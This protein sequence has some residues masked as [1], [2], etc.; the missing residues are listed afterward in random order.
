LNFAIEDAPR[1]RVDQGVLTTLPTM[2]KINRLLAIAGSWSRASRYI[3]DGGLIRAAPDATIANYALADLGRREASGEGPLQQALRIVADV[4][5]KDGQPQRAL[6]AEETRS[7]VEW[8]Q[9]WGLLGLLHHQLLSA[10][11]AGR[12]DPI[13]NNPDDDPF[14]HLFR[15]Q[16][17]VARSGAG[18]IVERIV[19]IPPREPMATAE[20]V[21]G[22]LVGVEFSESIIYRRFGSNS[23][24]VGTWVEVVCPYFP[25]IRGEG[26]VQE[27]RL[28]KELA[29]ECPS[30]QYAEPVAKMV[31]AL[32]YLRE[33]LEAVAP[34][35]SRVP[36]RRPGP[37]PTRLR[38]LLG[39]TQVSLAISDGKLRMDLA[40]GSPLATL[41]GSAAIDLIGGSELR[42]CE[43]CSKIFVAHHHG[44]HFCQSRCRRRKNMRLYRAEHR[45]PN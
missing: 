6:D 26:T 32:L 29:Y 21:A 25:C 11:T 40:P 7:L 30:K 35:P 34:A 12:W 9:S 10:I 31:E 2:K 45:K 24:D 18:R 28:I 44:A 15:H 3:V 38:A 17:A 43:D 42:H 13:R 1:G 41:A 16:W 36:P 22:S 27:A 23:L 4:P 39:P 37:D 19:T 20:Q 8:C 33:A 14:H 5:F